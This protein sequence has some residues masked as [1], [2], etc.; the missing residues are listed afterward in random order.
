MKISLG[1][2]KF[3]DRGFSPEQACHQAS[4]NSLPLKNR[5]IRLK[6]NNKMNNTPFKMNI[7]NKKT[8]KYLDIPL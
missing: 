1:L 6:N 4:E 3:I 7:N 8:L 5:G 2:W